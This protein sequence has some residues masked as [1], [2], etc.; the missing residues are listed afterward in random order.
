M[1]VRTLSQARARAETARGFLPALVIWSSW[2]VLMAG[3]N[4]ATPLGPAARDRLRPRGRLRRAGSVDAVAVLL[5]AGALGGIVWQ[6][7]RR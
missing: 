5:A 4:L 3:A 6:L 7:R 1:A 2:L